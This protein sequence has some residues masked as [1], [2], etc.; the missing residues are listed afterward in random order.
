MKTPLQKVIER[1]EDE[2]SVNDGH[3]GYQ[4]G[5]KFCIDLCRESLQYERDVIK[6]VAKAQKELYERVNWSEVFTK[7]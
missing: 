2:Y 6:H 7:K 1:L 4:E 5:I 3:T